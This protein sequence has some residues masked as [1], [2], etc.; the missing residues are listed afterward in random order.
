MRRG[1]AG[2]A[3]LFGG[4][5]CLLAPD[6]IFATPPLP[7]ARS[8]TI[9]PKVI[10]IKSAAKSPVAAVTAPKMATPK[11]AA[12]KGPYDAVVREDDVTVR[13]GPGRKYYPT[14][15]LRAGDRVR[16]VR[17]D[18]GGWFVI[19]PPAG[20]FSWVPA[21]AIDRA[22]DGRGIV[23]VSQVAARVG[24][25]ESDIRDI[26]SRPLRKG[27]AVRILGEKTLAEANG[28][29][30]LWYRIAPPKYEWRWVLGQFLVPADKLPPDGV[31][32]TEPL[33]E[34][35][36]PV[37]TPIE[38][39]A[40]TDPFVNT[41][42][43]AGNI[44]PVGAEVPET[45]LPIAPRSAVRRIDDESESDGVATDNAESPAN[46]SATT[47][48]AEPVAS[49][50]NM[51]AIPADAAP[52]EGALTPEVADAE[53]RRLDAKLRSVVEEE[54]VLWEFTGIR[55]EFETLLSEGPPESAVEHIR[56]RL[57]QIQT[58]E[59][60]RDDVLEFRRLALIVERRDKELAEKLKTPSTKP[61]AEDGG[62]SAESIK[63]AA[64][65]SSPSETAPKPVTALVVPTPASN[66]PA[67]NTP[68]AATPARQEVPID[69]R[70]LFVGAGLVEMSPAQRPDG[71]PPFRLITPQGRFLAWLTPDAGFDLTKWVGKPAG[72]LGRRQFEAR[73]QGDL[74]EVNGASPVRLSNG[75]PTRLTPPVR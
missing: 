72:L 73:L 49:L 67:S 59:R 33:P 2:L 43:T 74:I 28:Q 27:E 53:L 11:T 22:P 19:E 10:D 15:K 65:E 23:T 42:L 69:G 13:C 48:D 50:D 63:A 7:S 46:G 58:W 26:E 37:S 29:R 31:S 36:T 1:G 20:S 47:R 25:Y 40:G 52:Q 64:A 8:R 45:G 60:K 35:I 66:T 14:S 18:P 24:S 44:V 9:A 68:V 4:A 38:T 56:S 16:V 57:A 39:A 55:A 75:P 5:A 54:C 12:G 61:T 32:K 51:P 21:R 3:I 71:A 30:E 6:S 17:H 34:T 41:D 62:S 70:T